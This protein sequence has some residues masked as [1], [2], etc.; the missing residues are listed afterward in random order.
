MLFTD[1]AEIGVQLPARAIPNEAKVTKLRGDKVYTCLTVIRVFVANG[2]RKDVKAEDGSRFL[3]DGRGN[4]N[5]VSAD[6]VL[7][8]LTTPE[9]FYEVLQSEVDQLEE[10]QDDR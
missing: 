7:V 6:T 8:W 1:V 5:A 4:F 3:H 10:D 2:E 9:E